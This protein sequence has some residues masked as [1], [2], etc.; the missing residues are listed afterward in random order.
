MSLISKLSL[1]PIWKLMV[2][3]T[4]TVDCNVILIIFEHVAL[5]EAI[6]VYLIPAENLSLT[7]GYI[8][9]SY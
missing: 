5:I 7:E 2:I 4:F 3:L 9:W 6:T 8:K 1:L